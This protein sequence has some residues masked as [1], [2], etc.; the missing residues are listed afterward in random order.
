M[1]TIP[2]SRASLPRLDDR[3][4]VTTLA[5]GACALVAVGALAQAGAVSVLVAAGIGVM[6]VS[7][8]AALGLIATL[9]AVT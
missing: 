6:L 8:L 7:L 1:T 9:E 2:V 4:V 3:T 5:A